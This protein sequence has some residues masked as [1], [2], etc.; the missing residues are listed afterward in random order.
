MW[1]QR[2]KEPANPCIESGAWSLHTQIEIALCECF[3][4]CVWL[5]SSASGRNM[6]L[7]SIIDWACKTLD[8]P[9]FE[10][11]TSGLWGVLTA[12]TPRV[13]AITSLQSPTWLDSPYGLLVLGGWKSR[14]STIWI[15]SKKKLEA[16]N[17]VVLSAFQGELP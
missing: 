5:N 7:S 8:T 15:S 6:C 17:K 10:N 16:T 14:F 2:L 12:T 3:H 9:G 11:R 13:F 1:V 4:K